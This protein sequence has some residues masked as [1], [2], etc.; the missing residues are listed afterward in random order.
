[1]QVWDTASLWIFQ[2]DFTY[3]TIYDVRG[4][5][6]KFVELCNK[7]VNFKYNYVIYLPDV[8]TLFKFQLSYSLSF[9][10]LVTIVTHV[11]L[12]AVRNFLPK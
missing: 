9:L 11:L 12:V 10:I 5:F 4:L 7:T 1:M 2:S 8:N 3:F 6:D